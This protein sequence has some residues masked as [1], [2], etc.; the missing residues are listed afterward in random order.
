VKGKIYLISVE[1]KDY[2]GNGEFEL[3][4]HGNNANPKLV[5]DAENGV[6]EYLYTPSVTDY[7]YGIK[8]QFGI[9]DWSVTVKSFSIKE[10]NPVLDATLYTNKPSKYSSNFPAIRIIYAKELWEV[11]ESMDIPNIGRIQEVAAK[12]KKTDQNGHFSIKS[13]SSIT[14]RLGI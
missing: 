6:Q 12:F 14:P 5:F 2:Q 3:S 11:D 9:G 10:V 1:F 4:P 13:S 8:R 7:A